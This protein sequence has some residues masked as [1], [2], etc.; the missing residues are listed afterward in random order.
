MNKL[1]L[2][3]LCLFL[4]ADPVW[5]QQTVQ[6]KISQQVTEKLP[7]DLPAYFP[8]DD[9][10]LFEKNA[11]N[12]VIVKSD[13]QQKEGQGTHIRQFLQQ[14]WGIDIP[15]VSWQEAK[16]SGKHLILFGTVHENT[17]LRQLNANFQLG[18]NQLGYEVRTIFNALDWKR[19][20]IFIGGKDRKEIDE[21][22]EVLVRRIDNPKKIQHFIA[23]KGW[24]TR[25][26]AERLENMVSGLKAHYS[27]NASYVLTQFAIRDSLG[28]IAHLYKM[29]GYDPYAKTF[30][31]MQ[32]IVFDHYGRTINGRTE[33]APSFT[34]HLFPQFVYLM[35]HSKEFSDIDRLQAAE[36]IRKIAEE[37]LVHWE[38]KDPL[39]LYKDEKQEYL[40]NHSCFASRSLSS[41]GRY[42]LS[43][44]DYEPAKF[45]V[46]VA[47]NAFAGVA[48]RTFS[49]E[50]A[51]GY[52]YLVYQIF[53]D[54]ALAS[55][56]YDLDF[57]END[58]F[59]SY[60]E[61][62]KFQFN[63]LGYTAGYGDANPMGH[64]G[65]YTVL[66]Y[67]VEILRDKEA[68]YIVNLI[69]HKR[70]NKLKEFPY[71]GFP[72]SDSL[73]LK[74]QVV[75]PFKQ[76]QYG[77]GNYYKRETLDKAVFR[78]GWNKEADF[79]SI[80]GINGDGYNH[81]H[82]DANGISQYIAGDKLWLW[83]GD[84]IKKFPNDHNS[85]VVSKDGKLTDQ[86]RSLQK[87]RKSSLSQVLSAG[88]TP[89]R[90][91][92]LLSI[93]LE[94]Y[95]GTNWTRNINYSP[96][97]GFWVIDELEIQEDGQYIT[98]AY[99]RSTGQVTPL[100]QG[101]K[102]VQKKADKDDLSN[103]FF[104]VEGS[105]A[106][107]MNRTV[108]EEMHGRKDG[109]LS[110]YSFSDRNTQYIVQRKDGSYK[111][112]DKIWFVNF[113]Q[114]VAE[115][116]PKPPA[117]K[118]VADNV[119]LSQSEKSLKLAV[120]GR[121]DSDLMH[122]EADVCFVAKEGIVARG[123]QK[124]QVGEFKWQST[125]KKDVFIPLPQEITAIQLQEILERLDKTASLVTPVAS[126]DVDVKWNKNVTVEDFDSNVSVLSSSSGQYAV[127]LQN[128]TFILKD[129]KNTIL[130]TRK[131]P[132]A[133][134]AIC[135]VET[136]KGVHW[137]VGV[138]PVNTRK[139][140][141]ALYLLDTEANIVWEKVIPLYQR[142]NGK[143]TT[144]FT[145][146]KGAE[147]LI[148]AG[149][150]SWHYYAFSI[151]GK[152]I[153]KQAV[154]HGATT[155]AAGDMDGDGTDEIA[156][157]TEYYYHSIIK[158]GKVLPHITTSPWVY[159]LAV[160]DL[161]D[162][163]LKEAVYG[164]G[165]G[166]LYVQTVDSNPIKTWRLNIGGKPTA[167]VELAQGEAKL[168]VSNALGDITFVDGLGQVK[169]R[170]SLPVSVEDMI[171]VKQN[172]YA[173]CADGYVYKLSQKGEVL[174][175][176]AYTFSRTSIYSPK[177]VANDGQI[178]VFSGK[179]VY[180]IAP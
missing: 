12:V 96:K 169:G 94:D 11:L 89:D 86:S 88:N 106:Q 176:Y 167:I 26:S 47:D 83:E 58:V 111:K 31:R 78:S 100:S 4:L 115:K 140:E 168:A 138:A 148:I 7:A 81:G 107:R 87:R 29:T 44:Y 118:R 19:N 59:K 95:N 99:W 125:D 33:T 123:A 163:G 172:L 73:G 114:A 178:R 16:K 25:Y 108:L 110:G 141:G 23:C 153:W 46:A 159:A 3:V 135:A 65:G 136:F 35:E 48:P 128:G 174:E 54:Y 43:R 145:A 179:N 64:D 24:D 151:A 177:I 6:F 120:L 160:L 93:L 15:V 84:Y 154:Y 166:Y 92:S 1:L 161:N 170:V 45:W 5:S 113:M 67:A 97:D 139:G 74:Y 17:P 129:D 52:Q 18:D 56:I 79:L 10:S 162:D 173:V 130:A 85:I 142:R 13:D 180:A 49:P 171:R 144:I 98:E 104:V 57:F 34:F 32:K 102:I 112:G 41:A 134:T 117:I 77:V 116:T 124:L 133:I 8:K 63:H 27:N 175:K 101:Y 165:D 80:T 37:M 82:F 51:A 119:F 2:S 147:T 132:K 164:R 20:V 9:F 137:A 156:A 28:N 131:F 22:L 66:K 126:K 72:G 40:T 36:F 143:V 39:R 122:I 38:L 149:A 146:K 90:K 155:G 121:F 62:C 127:G 14:K 61:Y 30:A 91:S 21:G 109:N 55:G 60:V 42:L 158:D 157:G 105:G 68:A 69:E 70:K 50:D 152:Q 71:T 150:Q 103:T 53:M 76:E 75:V